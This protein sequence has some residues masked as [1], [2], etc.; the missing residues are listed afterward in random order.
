MFFG[1]VV[2]R[3]RGKSRWNVKFD[4]LPLNQKIIHNITR[5]KLTVVEEGEEEKAIADGVLLD[6]VELHSDVDDDDP[7]NTSPEKSAKK[8]SEDTFCQMDRQSLLAAD[9]YKMKWGKEES[10]IVEWRILRDGELFK[11]K[12]DS[13][14]LPDKVEYNADLMDA[15]LED[16]TDF[17]LNTYFLI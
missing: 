11:L 4:V 6:V 17:F 2:S 10:D 14:V 16:A 7:A 12:E 9:S 13:F 5:T 8:D 3:G 15:E 1:T